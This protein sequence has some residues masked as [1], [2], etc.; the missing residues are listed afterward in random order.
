M[1]GGHCV[2][3]LDRVLSYLPSLLFG[4]R[5]LISEP[6]SLSDCRLP[7]FCH[8]G[9]PCNLTFAQGDLCSGSQFL[10]P[11]SMLWS[12]HCYGSLQDC[13]HH[14]SFHSTFTFQFHVQ[15]PKNFWLGQIPRLVA[16]S[17]Y[18]LMLRFFSLCSSLSDGHFPVGRGQILSRVS[19]HWLDLAS[20]TDLW[21]EMHTV[22]QAATCS[23]GH[24]SPLSFKRYPKT[25][26]GA[27]S[28]ELISSFLKKYNIAISKYAIKLRYDNYCGFF[29]FN[30]QTIKI[31]FHKNL[32]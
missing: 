16:H 21:H 12:L 17:L 14:P 29:L 8:E 4:H 19:G 11:D 24:P 25:R 20:S 27:P 5:W 18:P 2:K 30:Y 1:E 6:V 3:W 26:E 31:K 23:T 7:S 28:E 9:L 32:L 22:A 15:T 10:F 13:V